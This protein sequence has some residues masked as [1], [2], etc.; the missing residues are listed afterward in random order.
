MN[1]VLFVTPTGRL[2]ASWRRKSSGA[3]GLYGLPWARAIAQQAEASRFDAI[4]FADVFW[5]EPGPLG[6]VP[7]PTGYEPFTTISALSAVT[8]HVGLIATAS[9]SFAHPYH[10][11]RYFASIDHL[12]GGR[13]GWNVVTSSAGAEVFGIPLPPKAERYD[14]AAEYLE[15]AKAFWDAWDDDAVVLDREAGVWA[16]DDRIHPPRFEGRFY[17]ASGQ[18]EMPRSPQGWPVIVQAGQSPAGMEFAARNAEVVFTAKSDLQTAKSFYKQLKSLA[19]SHGRD[20]DK[21]RILPGVAPIIGRTRSEA[22]EIADELSQLIDPEVGRQGLER[23]MQGADLSGLAFDEPIPPERL[24]PPD[25]IDSEGLGASRYKNY[26]D[27]AVSGRMTLRRLIFESEHALGHSSACGTAQ[28]VA[29]QL[30]QWYLESACDG[31]T[32]TPVYMPEGQDAV[33]DLLIPELRRRGLARSEYR[34]VTL[35][36]HFGLDRP[37]APTRRLAAAQATV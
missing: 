2:P 34:G 21:L 36:E 15:L 29:D 8:E 18:L 5:A 14:R 28:D 35:R 25:E 27:L 33:C 17:K 11:A 13:V 4:F 26:Y 12:S 31:F 3:E 37:A 7:F 23:S 32:I 22:L 9:T 6:K 20:P 10:L 24:T 1:L 19:A 30:E 16:R